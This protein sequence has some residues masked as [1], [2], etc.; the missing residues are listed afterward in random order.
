MLPDKDWAADELGEL[1]LLRFFNSTFHFFEA[2]GTR[3]A[4]VA[5]TSNLH[6]RSGGG[7]GA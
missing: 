6:G 5:V 7:H 3:A 1:K 2:L 4:I